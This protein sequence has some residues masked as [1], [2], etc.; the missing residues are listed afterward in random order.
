MVARLKEHRWVAEMGGMNLRF[1][2]GTGCHARLMTP[3]LTEPCFLGSRDAL[4]KLA[5]DPAA[6][7]RRER[8]APTSGAGGADGSLTE[9]SLRHGRGSHR[10][11]PGS[12][13]TALDHGRRQAR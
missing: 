13:R 2:Y 10:S 9:P 7:L 3:A 11:A 1:V 6:R 12:R 8:S 5:T 4:L